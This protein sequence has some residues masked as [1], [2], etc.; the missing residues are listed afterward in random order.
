[1]TIDPA[2]PAVTDQAVDEPVGPVPRPGE[3]ASQFPFG[4]DHGGTDRGGDQVGQGLA[5]IGEAGARDGA[6]LVPADQLAGMLVPFTGGD[7]P[8]A[9]DDR[10]AALQRARSA[11][12]SCRLSRSSVRRSSMLAGPASAR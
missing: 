4:R 2:Q 1:V 6:G 8:R 3:P 11:F 7:L 10:T 5:R 9:G 12:S